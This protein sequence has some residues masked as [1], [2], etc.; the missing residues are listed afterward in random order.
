MNHNPDHR[1]G[2][3]WIGLSMSNGQMALITQVKYYPPISTVNRNLIVNAQCQA[4]N[5]TGEWKDM[6]FLWEG[7][8]TQEYDGIPQRRIPE[9]PRAGWNTLDLVPFVVAESARTHAQ[10]YSVHVVTF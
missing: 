5:A 8:H 7:I 4:K 3:S 1:R 9:R 2:N 6:Y 10:I